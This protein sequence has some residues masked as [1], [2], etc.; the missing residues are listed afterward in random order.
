[1]ISSILF[2]WRWQDRTPLHLNLILEL[3]YSFMKT[4]N[5]CFNCLLSHQTFL[6]LFIQSIK[7]TILPLFDFI[8]HFFFDN[9]I[10][11]INGGQKFRSD[12]SLDNKIILL[13]LCIWKKW[14]KL[15]FFPFFLDK[16][17]NLNFMILKMF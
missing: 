16:I 13:R 6:F 17:L 10:W 3:Y 9:I 1:M 15:I 11:W 14:V 7:H 5:L 4:S 8:V 2:F 12:L